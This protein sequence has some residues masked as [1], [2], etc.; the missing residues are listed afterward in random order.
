M[1]QNLSF[2]VV[3]TD[4]E[5]FKGLQHLRSLDLSYSDLPFSPM[6]S[7]IL[8]KSLSNLTK[9]TLQNVGW[10]NMPYNIFHMLPY[11][12]TLDL[13]NNEINYLNWSH[14]RYPKYLK[15]IN[16]SNNRIF[17]DGKITI[18]S[19][20]LSLKSLDISNNS[21]YCTCD[22]LLFFEE[23][24]LHNVT[25]K[26][27]PEAYI[28]TSPINMAG[29]SIAD[30]QCKQQLEIIV[31]TIIMTVLFVSAFV[32]IAHKYRYRIRYL[33]HISRSRRSWKI[34]KQTAQPLVFDGFVIYSEPDKNWLYNNL[35]PFLEKQHGYKLCIHDRD[36][37]YGRLI[38]DNIVENMKNSRKI[39]LILSESFA[40]SKWCQFEVLLAHERFL[41]QGPDSLISIKLEE[42]TSFLMTN[43]L[44]TLIKF[45][46]H[47]VWSDHNKEEF[48][49]RILDC[50]QE[51]KDFFDRNNS[52][53]SQPQNSP[54][55]AKK[56]KEEEKSNMNVSEKFEQNEIRCMLFKICSSVNHMSESLYKRMD[57]L[58][59]SV[60]GDITFLK[61]KVH[62]LETSI[63]S[64]QGNIS[65]S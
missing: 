34:R 32:I 54:S 30:V 33:I 65:D 56:T 17:L 4:L 47:A 52:S 10:K 6:A 39:V 11:L 49:V 5:I 12:E 31:Y 26:H 9:L 59:E 55:H 61:N 21:I 35:L 3:P 57:A 51:K 19:S 25:I 15:E 20:V 50:F 62:K 38:V 53:R 41:E 42:I 8:F 37:Q 22:S 1:L 18:P 58:E 13:S 14:F 23:L 40:E 43:T 60:K 24:A 16:L 7:K 64:L 2:R 48:Y 36:F 29:K 44:E 46:T 63:A 45:A 27:H 28:C